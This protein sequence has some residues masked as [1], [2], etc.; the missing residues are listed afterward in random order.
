[1][2]TIVTDSMVEE[3]EKLKQAEEEWTPDNDEE[4]QKFNRTS[5]TDKVAR[6]DDLLKKA[7][8]YS[9]FLANK[10]VASHAET[11]RQVEAVAGSSRGKNGRKRKGSPPAGATRKSPRGGSK[12]AAGHAEPPAGAEGNGSH[13]SDIFFRQPPNMTGGVLRDYQLRGAQ[14]MVSLYENGLHGILADEMGL[15]KTIQVIALL[16]HLRSMGVKGAMM[17]CAPLSTLSNWQKEFAKWSPSVK[18]ILY[19]GSPEERRQLRRRH[20]RRGN[21]A[22]LPVVITSYEIAMRDRRMTGGGLGVHHW[23]YIVVDEGHRLKNMNC[24]LIRELKAYDSGNRLLLTGTPLQNNLSEL[25][26]LLN[27][28]LPEIFSDLDSFQ[29]WFDFSDKMASKQGSAALVLEEASDRIVSKL[30]EVLRP[31]LLRRLKDDVLDIK[32]K[33]E[34]V[35]YAPLTEAQVYFYQAIRDGRLAEVLDQVAAAQHKAVGKSGASLRNKLMQFRKCCNHPFLFD[36]EASD[37]AGHAANT[38]ESIVTSSGKM[39][40]TDKILKRMKKEGRKVLI[41]SQMTRMLDILEDYL[42]MRNWGCH[43]IDGAV[44]WRERQ[45]MMDDF[46]DPASDC[47]VFLLSTRAGGLGINLIAADTVIIYDS[48]WNP[49]QDSQAQDRC[50]RFGQQKQVMVYRLIT[51]NSVELKILA[52]ANSKRKL[53]RV[54]V[55]KGM[56]R[57]PT[58]GDKSLSK[59]DLKALLEDD[60]D[61][62]TAT[63]ATG[64]I[65]D[66]ELDHIMGRNMDELAAMT[67]KGAH[68]EIVEHKASSLIGKVD[69]VTDK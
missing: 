46:N 54:V 29:R 39:I 43:R 7:S 32:A 41:F 18:V 47:F 14:W 20:L 68:Y 24:R 26:S 56:F 25:W 8:V 4:F 3:E 35:V 5:T 49:H 11:M 53:E 66:S 9:K 55:S 63:K 15:G 34:I 37:D 19:H 62:K 42:A 45:M 57:K 58:A 60:V 31:F 10:I 30:H 52:R 44:N 50:H 36:I 65:S 64:G 28:L 48:D 21:V 38:D 22:S 69:E 17:V 12:S 23:K 40:I 16:S 61:L 59:D 33:R 13:A 2:A 6:L 27:F 67:K 1:M 51:E